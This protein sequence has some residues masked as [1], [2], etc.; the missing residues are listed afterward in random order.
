[1]EPIIRKSGRHWIIDRGPGKTSPCLETKKDAERLL[2]LA[3]WEKKTVR[4]LLKGEQVEGKVV[5][6]ALLHKESGTQDMLAVRV[7]GSTY[8]IKLELIEEVK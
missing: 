3:S 8:W 7:N 4:F 2:A 6:T 1:M 5:N